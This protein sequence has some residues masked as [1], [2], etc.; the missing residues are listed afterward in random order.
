MI[1]R[2]SSPVHQLTEDDNAVIDLPLYLVIT[3]IIGLFVLGSI[4]SMIFI[5][6]FFT[7]H[8]IISVSPVL[9]PINNTT[10]S[11]QYQIT[12]HTPEQ[13]PITNAHVIIKNQ[14]TIAT[15]TTNNTG[16]ATIVI[17]PIIPPGLHET[18]FD[19]IVR[20]ASYQPFHHQNMLKVILRC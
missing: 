14:D 11:I 3:L 12:V 2:I 10:A 13:T 20:T 18:Y 7:P 5:P 16:M 19:V 9:T 1:Q 15:N 6:T 8:P 17:H 4:L